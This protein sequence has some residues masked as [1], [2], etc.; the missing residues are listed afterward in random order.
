MDDL[1]FL[2]YPKKEQYGNNLFRFYSKY[3]M[4]DLRLLFV[5]IPFFRKVLRAAKQKDC[6]NIFFVS[7]SIYFLLMFLFLFPKDNTIIGIHNYEEH[8]GNRRSFIAIVKKWFYMRFHFFLFFSTLQEKQFKDKY[9]S[10]QSCVLRMPLKDFG[11]PKNIKKNDLTTFLFFGFIKPYKR[12]DLYIEAA[13]KIDKK[14]A[15]FII[16]GNC[17]NFDQY[18]NLINNSEN[19]D[20]RIR[21]IR[22]EEISNVFVETD[23][24][25]L[26]YE[27]TTQSGPLLIAVN[28][29]IPVVASDL[30]A[31]KEI[32]THG[33]NGFLFKSGDENALYQIF[34]ETS[35]MTKYQ[36]D[37]LK[38]NMLLFRKRYIANCSVANVLN[39]FMNNIQNQ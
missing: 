39:Q 29:G 27:D 19:F 37:D 9:G 26:P 12:L 24:L 8:T 15:R 25:V 18:A 2:K 11:E 30:P 13:K 3:R 17:D 33:Y 7:G 36:I 34:Y 31:F 38:K 10:K 14:N 22:N 28:Y 6:I 21:F 32:I 20:I 1:G 35:S 16:A 4:R 23:F 5:T